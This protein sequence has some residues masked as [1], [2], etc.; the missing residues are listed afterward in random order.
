M[1]RLWDHT[2]ESGKWDMMSYVGHK[3]EVWPQV[4]Q[5][6]R[7][8]WSQ[9]I[10]SGSWVRTGAQGFWKEICPLKAGTLGLLP[11]EILV[12]VCF[13]PGGW[14]SEV[15]SRSLFRFTISL[16]SSGPRRCSTPPQAPCKGMSLRVHEMACLC[17]LTL[18]CGSPGC[19]LSAWFG[20]LSAHN[21]VSQ[22]SHPTCRESGF[23]LCPPGPFL[24]LLR[25]PALPWTWW[26]P[27]SFVPPPVTAFSPSQ[28][29]IQP[30]RSPRRAGRST[31]KL[32]LPRR[33]LSRVP[34]PAPCRPAATCWAVVG[35]SLAPGFGSSVG[36]PAVGVQRG[37][38]GWRGRITLCW[39]TCPSPSASANRMLSTAEAPARLVLAGWRWRGYLAANAGKKQWVAAVVR[40]G[41][42]PPPNHLPQ[43]ESRARW[44]SSAFSCVYVSLKARF[45]SRL[46]ASQPL[47][48][49]R[50]STQAA[51]GF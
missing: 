7:P 27:A 31:G 29:A 20:V 8:R 34:L 10:P 19:S 32:T 5:A 44:Q 43:A 36:T 46:S 26:H 35:T 48:L 6:E 14:V 45:V 3:E 1:T 24:A 28:S 47:E 17:M 25:R 16:P 37:G 40:G 49:P 23:Y 50:C 4:P 42:F 41:I 18:N 51:E 39:Q 33:P 30:A 22:C 13:P 21:A 12:L 9:P 2:L 15:H 11:C 38:T